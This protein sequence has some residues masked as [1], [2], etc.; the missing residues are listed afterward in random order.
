[1][2]VSVES[3][4]FSTTVNLPNGAKLADVYR[5]LNLKEETYLASVDGTLMTGD[6]PLAEGSKVKLLPVVSGG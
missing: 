1:M 5:S 2:R 6:D 3:R 4:D